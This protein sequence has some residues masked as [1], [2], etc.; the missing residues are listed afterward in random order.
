MDKQDRKVNIERLLLKCK[1]G[2]TRVVD[3]NEELFDLAQ[4]TEDPD[5]A[6]MNLEKLLEI[7]TKKTDEII[8]AARGYMNSVQDKETAEQHTPHHS[9]SGSPMTSSKRSSQRQRDL[10]ISRLK[11]KNL[12]KSM[13]Q[14]CALL[15]SVLKL[16][17]KRKNKNWKYNSLRKNI[18]SR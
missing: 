17:H 13:R 11:G 14:S 4:K 3:K 1:D 12:R 9:R 6:C 8:A 5:A 7:A 18:A 16:K 10:E 15:D 2:F